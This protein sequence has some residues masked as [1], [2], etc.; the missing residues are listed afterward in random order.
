MRSGELKEKASPLLQNAEVFNDFWS[1]DEVGQV[2]KEVGFENVTNYNM[3]DR[4]M[5]SSRHMKLMRW[6]GLPL[7]IISE[8]LFHITPHFMTTNTQW[9]TYQEGLFKFGVTSYNVL[10]A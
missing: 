7:V 5:K 3:T 10:L 4:V 8:A 9:D 2:M 6:A 1:A